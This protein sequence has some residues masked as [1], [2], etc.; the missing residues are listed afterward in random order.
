MRICYLPEC[1]R[2]LTFVS[3]QSILYSIYYCVL[4]EHTTLEMLTNAKKTFSGR[5]NLIMDILG[6]LDCMLYLFVIVYFIV[7]L[8]AILR[9]YVCDVMVKSVYS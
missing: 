7:S 2:H 6:L 4:L 9:V 8:C 5:K 1:D 3:W